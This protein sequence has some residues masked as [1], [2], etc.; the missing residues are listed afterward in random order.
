MK[1]YCPTQCRW[2]F[3]GPQFRELD[4]NLDWIDKESRQNGSLPSLDISSL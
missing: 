2:L 3:E 1:N 4:F